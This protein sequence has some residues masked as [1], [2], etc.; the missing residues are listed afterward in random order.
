[1][2]ESHSDAEVS[3]IGVG[4]F[5]CNG[6]GNNRKRELVLEWLKNKEENIIFLP[7][8]HSTPETELLWCNQWNGKILFSHGSSNS[9]GVAILVKR[10]SQNEIK[11]VKH[12]NL[13]QGRALIVQVE[14][15]GTTFTLV[16]VYCPNNDDTDFIEKYYWNL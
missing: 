11:I 9:T 4:C 15:A 6:L 12:Q 5:N 13:H 14:S 3:E 10:D 1:M 8:T 7:E 2:T 16:N